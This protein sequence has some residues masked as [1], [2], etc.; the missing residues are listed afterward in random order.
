[1]IRVLDTQTGRFVELNDST[2][3]EY[4]ILSHTWDPSG[5]Q[6]YQDVRRIQDSPLSKVHAL[7]IWVWWQLVPL[8]VWILDDLRLADV[9]SYIEV[10]FYNAITATTLFLNTMLPEQRR[11]LVPLPRLLSRKLKRWSRRACHRVTLRD[12]F[13]WPAGL[14]SK[15]RRACAIARVNGH[16]YIWIDSCCIDKTSSAELSAAINSMYRWY[17]RSSVC[18]AFLS[19]VPSHGALSD[20]HWTPGYYQGR[21]QRSRWFSR[22]WTLQELIAPRVVV[23]LNE[24][25]QFIGTKASHAHL[26][27][28][29]TGIDVLVLTG[30]ME[31]REVSVARRLSWASLRLTTVVE[32]GAYSLLGIFDINMPTLYGEGLRAFVRLQEEI[33]KR[34]PDQSLFAWGAPYLKD[35]PLPLDSEEPRRFSFNPHVSIGPSKGLFASYRDTFRDAATYRAIPH[36]VLAQRLGIPEPDLLPPTYVSTPYGICTHLPL[37]SVVHAL[38]QQTLL[39]SYEDWHLAVLACETTSMEGHLIA[40]ICS[41]Q[42]SGQSGFRLMN[43]GNVHVCASAEDTRGT[44][45][46]VVFLSPA[47]IDAL[48]GRFRVEE[49]YIPP[50]DPGTSPHDATPILIPEGWTIHLAT[51][52]LAMLREL[53]YVAD[54]PHQSESDPARSYYV[55]ESM[56]G[57]IRAEYTTAV[58]NRTALQ[59]SVSYGPHPYPRARQPALRSDSHLIPHGYDGVDSG[60]SRDTV[61][62]SQSGLKH[63]FTLQHFNEPHVLRLQE[64]SGHELTV[65]I[66]ALNLPVPP[67]TGCLDVQVL[68]VTRP[69]LVGPVST[70]SAAPSSSAVGEAG[71]SESAFQIREGLAIPGH[72]SEVPPV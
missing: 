67:C 61:A 62:A 14:S 17:R 26:V 4:A 2:P 48:R 33:I 39:E 44:L 23:F 28:R 27:E 54:G 22:G 42:Q 13:L 41:I 34:N 7:F 25:W 57:W 40:L 50:E 36:N 71:Q 21:F 12:P 1:M 49:V 10:H 46:R 45:H 58:T 65:R 59:V 15:V 47:H 56:H 63:E 5:E 68:R 6:T 29:A 70:G 24:D 11:L 52:S 38:P 19:D 31:L 20:R 18:Y 64:S 72:L 35:L 9:I 32:D 60:S 3:I 55:L 8:L 16:R 37:I 51:W 66:T 30:E 43:G 53:G 69:E